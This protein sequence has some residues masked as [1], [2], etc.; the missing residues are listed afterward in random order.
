MPTLIGNIIRTRWIVDSISGASSTTL[1]GVRISSVGGSHV[2]LLS[3]AGA[4]SAE[5]HGRKQY[6]SLTAP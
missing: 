1:S 5:L 3:G 2:G 4:F 6:K